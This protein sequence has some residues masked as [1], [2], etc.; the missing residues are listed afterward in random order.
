VTCPLR[1][2]VGVVTFRFLP[3]KWDRVVPTGPRMAR[4][5]SSEV[6]GKAVEINFAY[7]LDEED[8]R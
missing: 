3:Q 7:P 6:W 5:V 2:G 4:F 1:E 8:T